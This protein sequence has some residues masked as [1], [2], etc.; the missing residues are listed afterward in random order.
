M[1]LTKVCRNA[2]MY[3]TSYI[4]HQNLMIRLSKLCNIRC[5]PVFTFSGSVCVQEALK[6]T[7]GHDEG[8]VTVMKDMN[9][10]LVTGGSDKSVVIWDSSTGQPSSK[11]YPTDNYQVNA[12]VVT[13]TEQIVVAAGLD[14]FLLDKNLRKVKSVKA[15]KS[16]IR[17]IDF[18]SSGDLQTDIA[19][20]S[21][22][23]FVK[24]WDVENLYD[25][26]SVRAGPV[27]KTI[28]SGLVACGCW[29]VALTE[30]RKLF[31]YD[32]S[33]QDSLTATKD[34]HCMLQLEAHDLVRKVVFYDGMA[35]KLLF[36]AA[37]DGEVG[38]W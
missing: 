13:P 6:L 26:A 29:L 1:Q 28:A 20:F 5:C 30:E 16:T 27:L 22:D 35:I 36:C 12:L 21:A 2:V 38:L 15:H 7:G 33:T 18:I 19:T 14:L 11:V 25:H 31:V 10:Q 8:L 37:S 17:D 9:G 24:M 32:A 34:Q 23:G 4:I 3:I